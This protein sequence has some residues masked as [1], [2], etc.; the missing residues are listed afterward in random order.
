MRDRWQVA[1]LEASAATAGINYPLPGGEITRIGGLAFVLVTD[2]TVANRQV[3]ARLEDETGAVVYAIAAPAV[4]TA[5][6]TVVY[7][8]SGRSPAFG[9]AAL[10]FIGGPFFDG[11]A[12][13]NLALVVS[14]AAAAAG[15]RLSA[16]R[17]L[18]SQHER[19]HG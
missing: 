7:S 17:L 2:G 15:D 13:N 5:S 11:G 10:G 4:Q 12:A 14:V 18:V 6:L 19:Q 9:T 8:F 1:A 3:V 16:A